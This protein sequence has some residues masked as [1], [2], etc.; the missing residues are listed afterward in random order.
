MQEKNLSLYGKH[1]TRRQFIKYCGMGAAAV[2]VYTTL[3][4]IFTG[5]SA[6]SFSQEKFIQLSALLTG[7]DENSGVLN[8]Q[9]A[10]LY[11]ESLENFPPS[12]VTLQQLYDKLGVGTAGPVNVELTDDEEKAAQAVILCWY[13][14]NYQTADGVKSATYEDMLAWKATDYV[15]PNAQCHGTM[16]FWAD[17][18]QGGNV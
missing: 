16:G 13:T 5:C 11:M 14:G 10:Q 9:Y 15:T 12:S 17:A 3:P 1:H 18:P 6:S 8:P 7:F 4:S 2:A